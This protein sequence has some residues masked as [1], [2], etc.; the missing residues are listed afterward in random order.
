VTPDA[1]KLLVRRLFEEVFPAG[2][3]ALVRDLMAPGFIDHD[4]IPGQPAGVEGVEYV[5]STLHTAQPDLRFTVD[6]L[7]AEGGSGHDPVDAAR[8][9]HGADA[10]PATERSAGPAVGHRDLPDRGRQDRG[11]LGRLQVR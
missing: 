7:V 1:N 9:Q 10:G 8:H 11:A 3:P 5:V 6:D 2:D 4:P